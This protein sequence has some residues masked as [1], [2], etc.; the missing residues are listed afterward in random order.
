MRRLN[1][2]LIVYHFDVFLLNIVLCIKSYKII[3]VINL[4]RVNNEHL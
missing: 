3:A 2:A 4:I 1:R